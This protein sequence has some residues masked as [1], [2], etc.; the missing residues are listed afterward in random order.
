[1]RQPRRR[2]QGRGRGVA[3]SVPAGRR[4]PTL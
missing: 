4:R 3:K 2:G 1:M